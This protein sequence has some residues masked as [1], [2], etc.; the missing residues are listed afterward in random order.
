[1]TDM[2]KI[3]AFIESMAKE[4]ITVTLSVGYDYSKLQWCARLIDTAYA[5]MAMLDVNGAHYLKQY[6]DTMEEAIATL[7]HQVELQYC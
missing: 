6:G 4:D 1:M 7:E 3:E 2:I 5:K